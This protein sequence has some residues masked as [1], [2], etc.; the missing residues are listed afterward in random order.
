MKNNASF[1]QHNLYALCALYVCVSA[2]FTLLAWSN[3][4]L[5]FYEQGLFEIKGFVTRIW[6]AVGVLLLPLT[7]GIEWFQRKKLQ[8]A[9]GQAKVV[10]TQL[11]AELYE[12]AQQGDVPPPRPPL[13]VGKGEETNQET[14]Q[15]ALLQVEMAAC[16]RL[17]K[18]CSEYAFI[19]PMAMAARFMAES[20]QKGAKVIC[21]ANEASQ[22]NAR[23]LSR[24]LNQIEKKEDKTHALCLV[25]TASATKASHAPAAMVRSVGKKNDV[26]V[27]LQCEKMQE[28]ATILAAGK[29]EHMRTI[30][31]KDHQKERTTSDCTLTVP[32]ATSEKVQEV[33]LVMLHA[34]VQLTKVLLTDKKA[35]GTP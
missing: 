23:H 13:S 20:I 24:L 9:I 16:G 25:D 7:L 34:I 18:R 21:F 2:C 35:N 27:V 32:E 33:H 15:L 28:A 12:H 6:L 4:H 19:E 14:S 10:I 5:G 30:W 31:F 3:E 26:L 11:K 17:L 1:L 22:D 8:R 29:K